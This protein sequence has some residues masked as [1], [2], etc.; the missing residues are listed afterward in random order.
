V[1]APEKVRPIIEVRG[2]FGAVLYRRGG[3]WGRAGGKVRCSV[4]TVGGGENSKKTTT[5]EQQVRKITSFFEIAKTTNIASI[6][7]NV[8]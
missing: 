5:I 7:C 4:P 2:M 1:L 8:H 6:R 3:A